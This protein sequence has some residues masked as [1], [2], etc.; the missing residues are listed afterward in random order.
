MVWYTRDSPSRCR[1]TLRCLTGIA[2]GIIEIPADFA[3][4]G[5]YPSFLGRQRN[6]SWAQLIGLLGIDRL[7][8]RRLH[9]Q[10]AYVTPRSSTIPRQ[11]EPHFRCL[12]GKTVILAEVFVLKENEPWN[13]PRVAT[14]P[15]IAEILKFFCLAFGQL[16]LSQIINH[17]PTKAT[18]PERQAQESLP[19]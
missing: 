6:S 12:L 3:P 2:S 5:C 8:W 4:M 9:Q 17:I 1:A 11:S 10:T 7:T 15:T 16:W 19:F 14:T 18:I 13:H